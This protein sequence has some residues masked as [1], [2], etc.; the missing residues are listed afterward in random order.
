M[1]GARLTTTRVIVAGT[2]ASGWLALVLFETL[3]P[4]GWIQHMPFWSFFAAL[5][6]GVDLVQNLVLFVPLGWIAHRAGWPLWR[7][8]LAGLLI[9]G[10]I[11]F[12]QQW[13]PGRT[14]TAMD[15][16]CNTAGTALGWW[17]A[18]PAR[19]PR[20]R[21]ALAFVVLAA[22]LGLHALNTAWP[23]PAAHVG[24]SGVWQGVNRHICPAPSGEQTVCVAVPNTAKGGNKHVV[25]AALDGRTFVHVQSTAYGRLMDRG[26][27]V[28][29]KFEATLGRPFYL[30]PPMTFACA[31]VTAADSVV[32]LRIDPR[33]EHEVAG[34]WVPTRAA[35]WMWPVWPFGTYTPALL[36]VAG[37]VTFVAGTALL[38][39]MVSWVLPAGYLLMLTAAAML[40]GFSPP[41]L[42]DVGWALAGLLVAAG[43]VP[44]D[45][46]WRS[47]QA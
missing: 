11:E 29:L 5:M 30:R 47:R 45:R 9:S 3:R 8:A 46:W 10:G 2:A 26:D 4:V 13:V 41:G 12:A 14:S 43:A 18:V 34:A 25:V 22:F 33:L 44:A 7:A 19:R 37:A 1:S 40:A 6:A 32:E 15:I 17:M 23:E 20:V 28:R 35:V 36:R 38:A 21:I 27:C 16:A 42:W 31:L 39:G 24:G